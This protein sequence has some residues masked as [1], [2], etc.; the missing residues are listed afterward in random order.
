MKQVYRVLAYLV[1]AGVVFQAA[2]IAY[3]MFAMWKWIEGGGT[4]DSSTEFGPALGGHYGFMLHG[5]GGTFVIP[6][7]ALL[8]L[9]S[10]FF[11]KIPGGIKWALIVFGVTVLQAALGL[12][13]H[14]ALAE[15]TGLGWLHGPNAMIVFGTALMAGIR[16][17]R[18]VASKADVATP[19]R[20][21]AS[22]A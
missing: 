11:A 22:V 13:A 3:G 19:K 18:A 8:F 21:A 15:L 10:S 14:P 6:V 12:L 16:V 17:K 2:S 4:F 9:I 7:L 20:A 1:A 5:I